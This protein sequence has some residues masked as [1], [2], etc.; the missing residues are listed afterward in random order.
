MN[1]QARA[2]QAPPWAPASHRRSLRRRYGARFLRPSSPSLAPPRMLNGK[3]WRD[4]GKTPPNNNFSRWL[5]GGFPWSWVILWV[6]LWLIWWLVLWLIL[7]FMMGFQYKVVPQFLSAFNYIMT[8]VT[9]LYGRFHTWGNP[10]SWIVYF[11]EN[12]G[13]L[14]TQF[15]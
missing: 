15:L 3:T 14:Q 6:I 10:H 8:M 5:N 1:H 9:Q 4:G 2:P 11:G 13:F 12:P 7:W